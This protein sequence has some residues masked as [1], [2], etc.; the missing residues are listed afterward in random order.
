M[1]ERLNAAVVLIAHHSK[2]GG[3]GTNGKYRVLGR[4]DHVAV[5]R[6]NFLFLQDPDDPTGRRRLPTILR[7]H[8]TWE[9]WEVWEV[10]KASEP[11]RAFI[12]GCPPERKPRRWA[13]PIPC[14]ITWAP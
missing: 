1:A 14:C 12:G 4:I 7:T 9:V 11:H 13:P 8:K 3:S 5:C 2:Q 6:V 10:W